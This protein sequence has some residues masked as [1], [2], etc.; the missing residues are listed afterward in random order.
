MR[1]K[2]NEGWRFSL[3]G[4]HFVEVKL[5]HEVLWENVKEKVKHV[6]YEKKLDLRGYEK[7]RILLHFHGVDYIARIFVND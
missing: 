4:V 2:L 5:P 1:L 7:K 3:D 6:V